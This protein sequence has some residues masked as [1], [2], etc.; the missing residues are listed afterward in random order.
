[1]FKLVVYEFNNETGALKL[2]YIC[3]R[4]SILVYLYRVSWV[5]I[6]RMRMTE[7]TLKLN[8]NKIKKRDFLQKLFIKTSKI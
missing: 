4:E 6:K 7:R 2:A 8:L 1:M 3:A 5:T